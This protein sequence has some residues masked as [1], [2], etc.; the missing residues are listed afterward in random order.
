MPS[1]TTIAVRWRWYSL[2]KRYELPLFCFDLRRIRY[3]GFRR[4]AVE[5]YSPGNTNVFPIVGCFRVSKFRSIATP[6]DD[7]EN[8]VR[9]GLVEINECRGSTASAGVVCARYLP[10][11]RC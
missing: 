7:R 10:A 1:T 2:V 5:R 6:D 8:L 4:S 9:I 3:N 11:Y